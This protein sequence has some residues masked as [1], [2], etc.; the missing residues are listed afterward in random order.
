[1]ITIS[2]PPICANPKGLSPSTSD[3]AASPCKVVAVARGRGGGVTGRWICA[4]PCSMRANRSLTLLWR[5]FARS[6]ILAMI[7]KIVVLE[8]SAASEYFLRLAENSFMSSLRSSRSTVE[9]SPDS[10]AARTASAR[11]PCVS[12]RCWRAARALLSSGRLGTFLCSSVSSFFM[13]RPTVLDV[14]AKA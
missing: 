13:S 3:G 5:I 1:M 4:M 6:L 7:C 2:V 10:I 14:V 9:F 12:T 8:T 11:D